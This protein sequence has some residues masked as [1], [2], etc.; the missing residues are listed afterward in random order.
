MWRRSLLLLGALGVAVR[1]AEICV[2]TTTGF[3]S[4]SPTQCPSGSR[5]FRV[6]SANQFNVL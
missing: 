3:A 6:A 5:P 1:G 4:I 2:D